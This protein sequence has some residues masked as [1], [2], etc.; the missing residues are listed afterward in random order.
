MPLPDVPLASLCVA[1]QSCPAS[2]TTTKHGFTACVGPGSQLPQEG[3][4]TLRPR[5]PTLSLTHE[6]KPH[7]HENVL[8]SLPDLIDTLQDGDDLPPI[9][10]DEGVNMY[11][12]AHDSFWFDDPSMDMAAS[13]QPTECSTPPGSVMGDSS[14]GS[15]AHSL[16]PRRLWP[17]SARQLGGLVRGCINGGTS[18]AVGKCYGEE[19]VE[20]RF[21]D[22]KG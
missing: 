12:T 3:Q 2:S 18:T 21:P 14:R 9:D 7:M 22:S 13:V 16:T 17:R 1:A 4:A 11:S 6:S 8:Y 15:S 20:R 5:R 19:V 10:G